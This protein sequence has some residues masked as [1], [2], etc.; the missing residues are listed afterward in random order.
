MKLQAYLLVFLATICSSSQCFGDL[1]V[2]PTSISANET[3]L[4][5]NLFAIGDQS[6]LSRSYVSGVTGFSDYI[7]ANPTHSDSIGQVVSF[8]P[9][10]GDV[11]IDI[12]FDKPYVLSAFVL[13]NRARVDQGVRDFALYAADNPAFIN[14][15]LVGNFTATDVLGT[16]DAIEAEVFSFSQVQTQF[17]RFDVL[18]NNNTSFDLASLGEVA[19]RAVPEP[20]S[21][22]LVAISCHVLLSRRKKR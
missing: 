6:G 19:F 12:Q 13:W 18:T 9:G 4:D 16:P 8:V 3:T 14:A 10:S 7:A 15:Q 17:I 21:M 11:T 22:T 1:I 5:N 2:G 20:S